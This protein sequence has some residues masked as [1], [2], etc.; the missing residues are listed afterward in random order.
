M[1]V[2]LIIF[3]DPNV[4]SRLKKMND[5]YRCENF[6]TAIQEIYPFCL[7]FHRSIPKY[8]KRISLKLKKKHDPTL[9]NNNNLD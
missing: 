1:R 8:A 9:P 7:G 6:P 3:N 4:F 2:N 5:T